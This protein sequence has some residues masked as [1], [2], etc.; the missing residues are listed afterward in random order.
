MLKKRLE[1]RKLMRIV[2]KTILYKTLL[3]W[4]GC[5]IFVLLTVRALARA[6]ERL[7]RSANV[8]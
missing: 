2:S 7:R 6:Q 1:E 8:H 5:P 3:H 4:R